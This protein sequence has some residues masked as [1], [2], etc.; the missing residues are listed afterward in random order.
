MARERLEESKVAGG[1]FCSFEVDLN[2]SQENVLPLV[3]YVC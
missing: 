2:Q 3:G 1:F